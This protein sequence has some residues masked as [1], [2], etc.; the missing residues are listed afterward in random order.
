MWI[1]EGNPDV[2]RDRALMTRLGLSPL[3]P[4]GLT[5]NADG[6]VETPAESA[7]HAPA[8]ATARESPHVHGPGC[9][10]GHAPA[11]TRPATACNATRQ[12]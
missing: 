7:C 12:R 5:A 3:I 11:A 8:E 1:A 9:A 2:A 10:H 6:V 4:P